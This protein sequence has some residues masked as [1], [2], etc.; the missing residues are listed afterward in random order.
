MHKVELVGKFFDNHSL[1]I[2]NRNLALNLKDSVDL[3]CVALDEPSSNTV[4]KSEIAEI[5]ELTQKD[6]FVPDIQ[7]RHSY[8]PIW[9]WPTEKTTRV[10][11]IQPWEFSSAPLEWQHKFETFADL[12]IVPSFFNAKT[13]LSAGL[14]PS[15]L[16][17]V[18]N[19]YNSDVYYNKNKRATDKVKVLY[20]GCHQ[21]RKGVDLLLELWSKATKGQDSLSLTIKDTPKVYG[22]SNLQQDIIKLQYQNKCAE[23]VYD[24]SDKTDAEMSDLYNEHHILVHP[25]RGEGFGMHVQEAMAC[26]CIPIVTAGGATDDFVNDYKIASSAKPVNMYDIFGL[27]PEDASTHMG[28]HKYVLEPSI[29]SLAEQLQTVLKDIKT[30]EVDTSKLKNWQKVSNDYLSAFDYVINNFE[31]TKRKE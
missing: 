9:N 8:P 5:V 20:V 12:V 24:D 28:Q 14:N 30:I 23:I 3:R 7:V 25:Y 21:Y 1:S 11:Y 2:V 6:E 15:R 4:N 22:Q 19:G 18:A 29:Q 13:Y 27:K 10:V 26:G 31:S 17:V 16:K